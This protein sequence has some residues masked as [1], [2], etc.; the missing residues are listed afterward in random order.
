MDREIFEAYSD[1]AVEDQGKEGTCPEAL[2]TEERETWH[3]LE[4]L[5]VKENR[6][7]QEKIPISAV[8][9]VLKQSS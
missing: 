8:K 3:Y 7:E 6:L 4:G 5:P 1:F 9:S 2:T